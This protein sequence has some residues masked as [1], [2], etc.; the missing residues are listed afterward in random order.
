MVP[1][2]YGFQCSFLVCVD[3]ACFFVIRRRGDYHGLLP[4]TERAAN[5]H[6]LQ[7]RPRLCRMGKAGLKLPVWNWSVRFCGIL[8]FFT[9][10]VLALVMAVFIAFATLMMLWAGAAQNRHC[11]TR[12]LFT[13]QSR[14]LPTPDDDQYTPE[15]LVPTATAWPLNGSSGRV[16]WAIL[17]KLL[18]PRNK[19]PSNDGKKRTFCGGI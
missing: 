3:A 4:E 16:S 19:L 18:M 11:R 17:K 8:V 13:R 6:D 15:V 5:R 10:P 14:R 1:D 9:I 2:I 12:H 7:I